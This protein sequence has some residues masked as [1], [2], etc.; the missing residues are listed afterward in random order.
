MFD[1]ETKVGKALTFWAAGMYAYQM[2]KTLKIKYAHYKEQQYGYVAT[3]DSDYEDDLYNFTV[4]WVLQNV[5]QD[6]ELKN[7][8][9]VS[10][11]KNGRNH[12]FRSSKD[13]FGNM[14]TIEG[15]EALIRVETLTNYV[16]N[17]ETQSRSRELKIMCKTQEALDHVVNYFVEYL[18][19]QINNDTAEEQKEGIVRKKYY[20]YT[21]G[22]WSWSTYV[23]RQLESVVLKEGESQQ[24]SED[25]ANFMTL[26][27]LYLRTSIPWHRGYL[28]H[29]PAG[30]GKTSLALALASSMD[31]PIFV[32]SLGNIKSD[33]ELVSAVT[34]MKNEAHTGEAV[35]ILE[36]ID[37]ALPSA[38]R[39]RAH[40]SDKGEHG[41][42]TLGGLLNILDGVSTPS[43]LITIMTTN[44][45]D[46]LDDALIR[47][48]RIDFTLYV[49]YLDQYQLNHMVKWYL[50]DV[51][52]KDIVLLKDG[53]QI[54]PA[55]ITG[56][57]K[58][59]LALPE[60]CLEEINNFVQE[61]NNSV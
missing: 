46:H 1:K 49:D 47:P 40:K 29:G 7:F 19:K 54:T 37:T 23:P 59:Y 57:V 3:I 33:T 43:G 55:E 38:K 44:H 50:K 61:K 30:T 53:V 12:I 31:L 16:T 8:S 48:G 52:E 10:T 41:E 24:I 20:N 26:K 14:V 13:Q 42:L 39:E 58:N 4:N 17:D 22:G 15:H 9:L 36:D 34:F 51:D 45:K 2:S 35:L 21:T 56:V 5:P 60:K 25:L 32:L 28:F 27:P 6:E 18:E 11:W